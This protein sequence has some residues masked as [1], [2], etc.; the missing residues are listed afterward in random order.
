MTPERTPAPPAQ[1]DDL[2]SIMAVTRANAAAGW[3]WEFPV[4]LAVYGLLRAIGVVRAA[5]RGPAR[6]PN[7]Q[8][9]LVA[10]R[11]ERRA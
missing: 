8:V 3:P 1:V 9:A 4:V 5:F 6:R 2:E 11:P 7:D 10:S